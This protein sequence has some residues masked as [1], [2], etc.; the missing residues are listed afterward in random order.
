MVYNDKKATFMELLDKDLDRSM[1][2]HKKFANTCYC[3]VYGK[4]WGVAV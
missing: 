1:Y 4:N 2:A 3:D